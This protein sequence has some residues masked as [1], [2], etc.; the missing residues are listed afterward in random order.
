MFSPRFLRCFLLP[1]WDAFS[2]FLGCFLLPFWTGFP[3]LFGLVSPPFS[4]MLL[5]PFWDIFSPPFWDAFPSSEMLSPPILGCFLGFRSGWQCCPSPLEQCLGCAILP[6]P[7]IAHFCGYF[8]KATTQISRS[9][10]EP[11]FSFRA[12]PPISSPSPGCAAGPGAAC[13][14][15]GHLGPLLCPD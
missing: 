12:V 10:P 9:D 13:P 11:G 15:Q 8:K 5:P 3:L 4:E 2:P 1:F 14:L 7:L 6:A